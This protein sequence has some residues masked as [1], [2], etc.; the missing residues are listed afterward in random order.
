MNM[1]T[2]TSLQNTGRQKGGLKVFLSLIEYH[3]RQLRPC[4]S[5]TVGRTAFGGIRCTSL[6]LMPTGSSS[7]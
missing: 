2:D 3:P 4:P 1:D 7:P 6:N 5:Q